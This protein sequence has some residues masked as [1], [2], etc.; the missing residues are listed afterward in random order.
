MDYEYIRFL[1]LYSD[2]KFPFE[3]AKADPGMTEG[4]KSVRQYLQNNSVRR[5]NAS[6]VNRMLLLEKQMKNRMAMDE[7]M[8]R[9][10]EQKKSLQPNVPKPDDRDKE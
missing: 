3:K 9:L 5:E 10:T 2:E 4:L 6:D 1:M 7:K 8:K